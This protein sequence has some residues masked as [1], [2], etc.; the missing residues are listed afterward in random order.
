M[1]HAV[2]MN[3]PAVMDDAAMTDRVMDRTMMHGRTWLMPRR[4]IGC[5]S[6]SHKQEQEGDDCFHV[7]EY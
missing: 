1:Y 4:R 2:T 5:C 7:M 6:E 3:H